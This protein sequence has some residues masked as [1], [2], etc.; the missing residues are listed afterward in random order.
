MN[1]HIEHIEDNIF[2]GGVDGTRETIDLLR[3]L[4]DTLAGHGSDS[5]NLSIKWDGSPSIFAG[6]DP[7]D[8]KFFV[9]SKGLFNKNPRLYKTEADIDADLNGDLARKFKVALA[10]LPE[11]NINGVLRGDFLFTKN[12]LSTQEINDQKYVTFHPNTIVY[13]VPADSEVADKIRR[14]KMGIAWHES[15]DMDSGK[16]KPFDPRVDI[17][18]NDNVWTTDSVYRDVSGRATLTSAQSGNVSRILTQAGRLFHDI[19]GSFLNYIS[20][21]HEF[22]TRMKIFI[23][24]K[25]RQGQEQYDPTVMATE[26]FEYLNGYYTTEADKRATERGKNSVL[27]KHD[28]IRRNVDV[29]ALITVFRLYNK[30]VEAKLILIGKLNTAQSLDTFLLTDKGF[31]VTSPEG[32]VVTDRLSHNTVKLVDRLEF[33]HANFSKDVIKGF[34]R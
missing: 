3:S 31:E 14:A 19:D 22:L 29:Q 32:F 15:V 11:L 33:S 4:R 5:I 9:A 26:F 12:D 7:Q 34:E 25:V 16:T 18:H 23:N 1:L 6:T 21:D 20:E 2:N 30:I 10:F 17:T 27:L 13:A 24:G 8:G 28:K